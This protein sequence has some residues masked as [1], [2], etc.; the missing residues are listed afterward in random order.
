M[1]RAAR[2]EFARPRTGTA[3]KTRP[4][5]YTTV[6]MATSAPSTLGADHAAG[7]ANRCWAVTEHEPTDLIA[8]W[9]GQNPPRPDTVI[10]AMTGE[11]G[12]RVRILH[13]SMKP[14]PDDP[15][16]WVIAAAWDDSPEPLVIWSEHDR[17]RGRV[18]G[19]ESELS[20]ADPLTA[21]VRL[22]R[23]LCAAA[24]LRG[25]PNGAG[26]PEALP[27]A[28]DP[29]GSILDVNTGNRYDRTMLESKLLGPIE[30]PTGLLW[31]I[32]A[33]DAHARDQALESAPA[34]A[35]AGPAWVFS[36][37]LA[38]TGRPEIE[39]LEVAPDLAGIAVIVLNDLAEL[40]LEVELP[41]PGEPL[42]IGPGLRIAF[43]PWE[44]AAA[45]VAEGV[46][47]G[48]NRR[49]NGRGEPATGVRA[50]V[51][52]AEPRGRFKPVWTWPRDVL[53]TLARDKGVMYRSTRATARQ[54][55]MARATWSVLAE[56][57][58]AVARGA[59]TDVA[60]RIMA[61]FEDADAADRGAGVAGGAGGAEHLWMEPMTINGESARARL[62]HDALTIDGLRTGTTLDVERGRVS[63]WFVRC[64]DLR[65]D[66]DTAEALQGWVRAGLP[67]E[68]S[69]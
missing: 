68:G 66:P 24:A 5:A 2:V 62:T 16:S 58:Q 67:R 36:E 34:A 69:A 65:F 37:G 27:G 44:V 64:G 22:V 18:L 30:P 33:L 14:A 52:A 61:R 13:R 20:R 8:P 25:G 60:I 51:C 17:S 38:R 59:R 49:V 32:H 6:R 29:A 63:D 48:M 41:P 56:A 42:E 1:Q 40:L 11:I 47:G 7:A 19:V 10:S 35:T 15:A 57:H 46:R 53:E 21:Y 12:H 50:A 26:A 23:A 43:Q 3:N 31:N 45:H 4:A 9:H 54:T 39:M 28:G 55:A